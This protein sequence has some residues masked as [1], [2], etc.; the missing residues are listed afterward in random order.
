MWVQTSAEIVAQK[1][2]HRATR[3]GAGDLADL[4]IVLRRERRV[5]SK[6]DPVLAARRTTVLDRLERHE[7]ALRED[8]AALDLLEPRLSFDECLA[9]ARK[10]LERGHRTEQ[11]A[12]GYFLGGF[13]LAGAG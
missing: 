1:L 11:P 10:A 13:A 4:A 2:W 9:L 5:L 6:L 7:A 12:A 3:F 8:F